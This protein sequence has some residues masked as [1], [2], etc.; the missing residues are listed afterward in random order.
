MSLRL[1]LLLAVAFIAVVALVLADFATYS[2]LRTSLYNQVDQE[3]SQRRPG[4]LVNLESQT[5]Y[6]Q[7]PESNSPGGVGPIDL[8]GPSGLNGGEGGPNV[9]GILYTAVA[10]TNGTVVD[11]LEC[12]AYI[13]N[14]S[15][16]PALPDPITA[17]FTV[18]RA[19]LRAGRTYEQAVSRF[20]PYR[21]VGEPDPSSRDALVQI[22]D[23]AGR[24][25]QPAFVF[26]NNRLEGNAPSTIEAVADALDSTG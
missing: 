3:L 14:H 15:Y 1:R 8:G 25:G 23:R 10:T 12:P 9:F 20:Y 22:A 19:L 4:P 16:R 18:V 26:V 24:C 11:G 5:A 6:C 13:D 17:D 21:D 2:A 7:T